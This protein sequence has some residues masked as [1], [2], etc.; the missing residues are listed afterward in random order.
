MSPAVSGPSCQLRKLTFL[1]QDSQ[2]QF[3]RRRKMRSGSE[4]SA[5]AVQTK[6]LSQ[7]PARWR[8]KTTGKSSRPPSWI[9]ALKSLSVTVTDLFYDDWEYEE[10]I[11]IS[12]GQSHKI[13]KMLHYGNWYPNKRHV[14][15]CKGYCRHRTVYSFFKRLRISI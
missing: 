9:Q 14:M 2:K 8:G 3:P 10:K 7:L 4:L 6:T 12:K 1:K 13:R 15:L 5:K 11:R